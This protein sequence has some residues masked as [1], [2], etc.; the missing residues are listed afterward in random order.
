MLVIYC[1]NATCC[2]TFLLNISLY[3]W[4]D[5]LAAAIVAFTACL[6]CALKFMDWALF[7]KLRLKF[8][9]GF[10]CKA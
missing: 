5:F 9:L 10:I 7:V 4:F 1:K 8:R 6:H 2:A 3:T